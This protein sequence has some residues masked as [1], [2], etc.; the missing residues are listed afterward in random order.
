MI[1]TLTPWQPDNGMAFMD[2]GS[3]CAQT[4]DMLEQDLVTRT[5]KFEA[6]LHQEAFTEVRTA[7]FVH[8]VEVVAKGDEEGR[9]MA[10]SALTAYERAQKL[11]MR[12]LTRRP[13][14]PRFA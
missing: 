2:D 11:H 12:E 13:R 10:R 3:L 4:K 6:R 14:P 5:S 8:D 7:V 1:A 9:Q